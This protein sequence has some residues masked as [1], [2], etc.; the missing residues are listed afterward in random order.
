MF[1][2]LLPVPH[3][4]EAFAG[5]CLPAYCQMALALWGI[6]K[7]QSEIATQIGYIEGAGTA[8]RNITRLTALG[9]KVEWREYGTVNEL[10]QAITEGRVPVVFL[11]TG[12][13]PY[14]DQDVPHA[15]IIVS[16]EVDTVYVNDP[17]FENA[18]IPVSVGD[19]ELAWDEFQRQWATVHHPSQDGQ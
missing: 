11:R 10:G 7:S 2:P 12:E 5:A 18:P 6:S 16:V 13:L 4:T 9:V 8:A 19:F 17:A 1:R 3:R 15:L 14:W